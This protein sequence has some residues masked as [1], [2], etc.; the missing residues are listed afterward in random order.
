MRPSHRHAIAPPLLDRYE[1][2][3]GGR[4]SYY[5]HVDDIYPRGPHDEAE[6]Y[7][8]VV[9]LGQTELRLER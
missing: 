4:G 8:D 6:F 5:H 1:Q 9:R 2:I 7:S 3:A